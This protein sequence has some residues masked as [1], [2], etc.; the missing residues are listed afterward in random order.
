MP[1]GKT[2]FTIIGL[3]V[4]IIAL[5]TFSINSPTVVE[6]WWNGIQFTT[7]SV[8]FIKHQGKETAF[9]GSYVSPNML[10]NKGK[11]V[12]VPN[13]Q[14]ILSPRFSN[15]QYGAHIKYST[16]NT[17]NMGVPV[18]PLTFGNMTKENFHSSS[19]LS[20]CGKGNNNVD[21]VPSS[22]TNG[23]RQQVHNSLD[24][25]PV[26]GSD[27]PIGTMSSMDGNGNP[28]QH[29]VYNRL[30]VANTKSRLRGLGDPIRGDLAIVPCQSGWF[31]VSP[32]LSV[33]LNQGA[34]NVMAGAGGGGE[35]YN[36]LMNLIMSASGGTKTALGGVDLAN[37]LPQYKANMAGDYSSTLRAGMSD[38]QV[39][40]FP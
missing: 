19:N 36:K 39:T 38:L 28:E 23:N 13:Y 29:V 2:L 4:A 22:Y 21:D 11:F 27:L 15:T 3:F 10:D 33:D 35:S 18:D 26:S 34:M 1:S 20:S 8:P 16:P 30:M 40:A 25:A 31:S 37:N 17:Q 6:N 32:N 24:G 12:S 9:G 14:S 7:K 5:S